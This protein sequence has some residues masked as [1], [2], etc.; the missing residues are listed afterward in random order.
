MTSSGRREG[1]LEA[2]TEKRAFREQLKNF[3]YSKVGRRPM[4]LCNISRIDTDYYER[5]Y[6]DT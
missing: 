6:G 2:F 5:Y 1:S 3:V 4:V